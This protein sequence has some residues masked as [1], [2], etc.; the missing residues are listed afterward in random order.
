MLRW[1]AR[2]LPGFS[3]IALLFLIGFALFD[4]DKLLVSAGT[5]INILDRSSGATSTTSTKARDELELK[6]SQKIFM[7]Y[8]ILTHLDTTGFAARLC[9]ALVLVKRNVKEALRRRQDPLPEELLRDGSPMLKPSRG[10][11][12][13]PPYTSCPP[14]PQ[15]DGQLSPQQEITHAII[16]PNYS[17]TLETLVTTLRVLASHPRAKTQYEV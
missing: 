12:P 8:F 11:S 15:L 1:F 14:S 4:L 2:C 17:E 9:L 13:P 5:R 3:T 7:G 16:V 10:V 6:L